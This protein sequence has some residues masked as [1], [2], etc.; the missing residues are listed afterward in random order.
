MSRKVLQ[1]LGVM[2]GNVT[3]QYR[4]EVDKGVN[5]AGIWGQNVAG[6]WDK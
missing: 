5:S 6:R 3:L 4:Q 1:F 2:R